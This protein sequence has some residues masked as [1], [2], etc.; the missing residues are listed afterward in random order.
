MMRRLLSNHKSDKNLLLSELR[1]LKRG[2]PG[3]TGK[4]TA[5]NY[6]LKSSIPPQNT[7]SKISGRTLARGLLRLDGGFSLWYT[8][9]GREK[10]I[11]GA[12]SVSKRRCK[13]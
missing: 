3:K 8:P 12:V 1:I 2:M 6:H 10:V 9:L 13:R 4:Y 5:K 11:F 7:P